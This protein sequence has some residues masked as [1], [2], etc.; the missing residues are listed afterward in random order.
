[1]KNKTIRAAMISVA[2]WATTLIGATQQPNTTQN[3]SAGQQSSATT[4]KVQPN[5]IPEEKAM[6]PAPSANA[7]QKT[8]KNSVAKER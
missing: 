1:M 8:Q 3:S 2:V 6:H 7:E 4:P 5:L